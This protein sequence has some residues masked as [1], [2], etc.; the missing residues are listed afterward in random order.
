VQHALLGL[1]IALILAIAAALAAPAYIDW[2]DWRATIE[3][4]ATALVGAPVRI[5]GR[6]EATLLP[7]PAFVLRTVE[8]GDPDNGTGMR[9]GEARGILALGALLRGS[10]EAEEFVLVRPAFRLTIEPGG[11]P[12]LPAAGAA[13]AATDLVSFARIAIEGGSLVVEDR[14]TR[15]LTTFDD[16]S[17][18]G[19]VNGRQGPTRIDAT[20]RQ[21]K[22]RLRVR[23]NAGRFG[24]DRS[25]RVRFS[26]EHDGEGLLFEAD[27]TLALAGAAPRF[28]GKLNIAK[29]GMPGTPWQLTANTQAT[30]QLIALEG[31]ELTIGADTAAAELTGQIKFAPRRGGLIEGDLS[32]RRIDLDAA[33]AVD[34]PKTL[35]AALASVRDVLAPIAA[36]PF[37]G[38]IG[39]TAEAVAAGGATLREVAV[40][41]GLREGTLALERLDARVPGRGS[42]RATGSRDGPAIFAGDALIEAAD[43]AAFARWAFG[44]AGS[45]DDN[46]AVRLAGRVDWSKE[47][48]VVERLDAALAD[49]KIGGRFALTPGEG[50]RRASVDAN[51]TA[52]G[53]D[54]DLLGPSLESLRTGRDAID[55]TL[56]VDGRA[57]RAYGKPVRRVDVAFSRSAEGFAIERLAVEDFDGLN[58]RAKG[59]VLAP[60]ERPS[61]KIDFELDAARPGGVA[62]LATRFIGSDAGLLAQRLMQSGIPLKMSG[63]ISGAGVA[64]GIEISAKGNLPGIAAQVDATFDLLS[65]TLSEASIALEAREFGRLVSLFG[66]TPG[67]P[68]PGDGSLEI[69]FAKSG[70]GAIPVAARLTVPGATVTAHGEL[71]QN[72]EG[73]IEPRFE[74][75]MDA[76]DLRSLLAA[77]GRSGGDAAVPA[78]GTVRFARTSDAFAFESIFLNIG[79]G[80]VR[81]A[82]AASGL[83]KPVL[84]GKLSI[85]RIELADL[86]GLVLGN[87]PENRAF[88]PDRLGPAPLAGATG[89]VEFEVAALGLADR[90]AAIDAKFKLKL[91]VADAALEDFSAAFAGGKLA[92]HARFERGQ[93]LGVDASAKFSGI[94]VAR[95]LSPGTWRAAARGRSDVTLT[96]TGV[97]RTPAAL[98]AGLAGQGTLTLEELEIDRLDPNA[99]AAVFSAAESGAMPDEVGVVAALAPAFARGPLRV[100]RV[101]APLVVASGVMRTG[102]ILATVGQTQVS[103]AGNFDIAR[104]AIDGTIEIEAPAPAGLTARPGA[105]VRWRGPVA[106]PE[107]GIE[108]AALATAI[109]L[110][111]MERETKR[112]EERDRALPPRRS[113]SPSGQTTSIEAAVLPPVSPE[114]TPP[115]IEA[116]TR[117]VPLPPVRPRI[118]R[119][120]ADAIPAEI[121]PYVLPQ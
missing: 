107:R 26:L 33:V 113:D 71:R 103:A 44:S 114:S 99:V 39:L 79:G 112:I 56:A 117:Q 18:T 4:Q 7:T 49:A 109:T 70:S 27:G 119:P 83:D 90:L 76:A 46:S 65:E 36:L 11:R 25:G 14:A 100:A 32:A 21:D 80:R 15:A 31:F 86:L 66:L 106:A 17:A 97:G 22:R 85:E 62:E 105:T 75:R 58:V 67:P 74:L 51:L 87:A 101:E 8:V 96:L 30:E 104:L 111:A 1:A 89:I 52:H 59:K 19:E 24:E 77:A 68:A 9:A 72:D 41:L 81:G 82:I 40:D 23:A 61:G 57:L 5:R 37:R 118:A 60:V 78:N 43:S 48:M 102:K 34:A 63:A 3:R 54:L 108:A 2:D 20:L 12:L 93:M 92:G 69:N 55:L 116:P 28:D 98:A 115:E 110:R 73:R 88:W 50:T 29:R 84:R 94:D 53:V 6:I 45:L 95:V 13:A 47:R 91:G 10:V 64:A 42:I 121:R 120:P 35:S 16:I 38:R